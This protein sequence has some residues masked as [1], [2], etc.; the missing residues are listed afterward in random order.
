MN[1]H[2]KEES[3]IERVFTNMKDAGIR[4]LSLELDEGMDRVLELVCAKWE[5]M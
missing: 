4:A 5:A 2:E 1:E 3:E